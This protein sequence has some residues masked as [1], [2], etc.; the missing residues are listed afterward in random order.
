MKQVAIVK[1]CFLE[2]VSVSLMPFWQKIDRELD[3]DVDRIDFNFST[4]CRTHENVFFPLRGSMSPLTGNG[5]AL[6]PIT[7]LLITCW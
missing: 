1:C 3:L 7:P 2:R 6:K 5:Y 4:A